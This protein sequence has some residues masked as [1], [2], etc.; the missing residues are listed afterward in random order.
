MGAHGV[1]ASRAEA[2]ALVAG[3]DLDADGFVTSRE[4]TAAVMPRLYYLDAAA[5]QLAFNA[6][7]ADKDGYLT[8]P[9][10]EVSG[11]AALLA[12][13]IA[14]IPCR[15]ALPPTQA[16]V[17]K[18][19]ATS[20]PAPTSAPTRDARLAAMRANAVSAIEDADLDGVGQRVTFESF[21]AVMCSNEATM[22]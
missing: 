17:A 11:D 19:L 7:D 16:F 12:S 8:R 21:V 10:L 22:L 9:D 3:L 13:R 20:P 6:L 15:V 14:F 18:V 1:P 2:A 4:F 5:L